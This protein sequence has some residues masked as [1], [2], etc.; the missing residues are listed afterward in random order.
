MAGTELIALDVDLV[1]DLLQAAK[2]MILAG[3]VKAGVLVIDQVRAE[4]DRLQLEGVSLT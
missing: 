1:L 4:I 2:V 3:D